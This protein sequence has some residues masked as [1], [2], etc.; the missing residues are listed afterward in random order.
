MPA[1]WSDLAAA[2]IGGPRLATAADEA[3]GAHAE[4]APVVVE[5]AASLHW[6]LSLRWLAVTAVVAATF[7]A[8]RFLG[9]SLPVLSILSV[10]ASI[11]LYNLVLI[12]LSRLTDAQSGAPLVKP[13]RLAHLQIS[14]DLAALAVLLHF[15]GGVENPFSFFYVFHVV[16]AGIF[17]SQLPSIAYALAATG[18]FSSVAVTEALGIIP[19]YHLE[20]FA[21]PSLYRQGPYIGAIVL[22]FALTLLV[23][24]YLTSSIG[25]HLQSREKELAWTKAKL[26]E[27]AVMLQEV[28]TKLEKAIHARTAPAATVAHELRAP[29]AAI[30]GLLDLILQ[31]YAARSEVS[32]EEIVRMA[33]DSAA[34]LIGLVNDLLY[35]SHVKDVGALLQS[36]DVK[37]QDILRE[38][39][40]LSRGQATLKNISLEL[41]I[42]E[43]IPVVRGYRDYFR[44]VV[45][46]LVDN[47]IKYTGPGGRVAVSL[48]REGDQLVC[49]VEDNG[50][51]IAS[52]DL[53]RIFDEFYRAEN[54]KQTQRTGTGLGLPIVKRILELHGGRIEVWSEPGKGSRFTFKL[55]V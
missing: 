33:R 36:E 37:L 32:S 40:D 16:I 48:R 41:S 45:V 4:P 20:G 34:G 27:Q 15:S 11:A 17:L 3:V 8:S 18:L 44:R 43:P 54:A 7:V 2:L 31:G 26:Q 28:N 51:G 25:Q 24:A 50:I 10:A 9:V 12:W 39:I 22:G 30:Q 47:A 23:C 52:A 5:L 14:L 29:L 13:A 1:L 55:P 6:F 49:T 46:N 35:L 38:V 53:T 19:H 42:V 21:D